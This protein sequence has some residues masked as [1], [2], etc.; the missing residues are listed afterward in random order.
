[1]FRYIRSTRVVTGG[2]LN[3]F[4]ARQPIFNTDLDIFGYELLFRSS[5]ENCFD[6]SNQD[7]A[8]SCVIANSF[9]LF[10]LQEITHGKK[11]FLNCT[12][13]VLIRDYATTFPRDLAIIELLEDIPADDEV[14]A[15]CSALKKMGYLLALDDFVD[16]PACSPLL[17]YADIIKVDFLASSEQECQRLIETYAPRGIK[18]LAEKV[19]TQELYEQAVMMGYSYFQ[20][21]FFS[22][23][24][25]VSRKDI[26]TAKVHHLKII[27]EINAPDIDLKKLAQ[28][29]QL[30]ISISYKLL[31]YINSVGF[32]LACKVNSIEHALML[33]GAREA[34]KWI[35]LIAMTGLGDDK[36]DELILSSLMRGKACETLAPLVDMQEHSSDVFLM[37]L[38]SMLDALMGR[39]MEEVLEQLP[40]MDDIKKA[41]LGNTGPLQD[42]LQLVIALERGD[43]TTMSLLASDLRLQEENLGDLH[44]EAMQW[45]QSMLNL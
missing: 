41:L 33:L 35:S 38:F 34:R 6:G 11:A 42:L 30:D 10:D 27:Q 14:L 12:R 22:K 9:L 40:I 15:A 8:S 13:N 5:L 44:L 32:G 16:S 21:Y 45:A 19:E 20:G 25:I 36:P 7:V 28:T 3:R 31:K 26:S 17:E 18:F 4:I 29:I 39:P 1:M 43:W 2:S 23:P 24:V 37:G